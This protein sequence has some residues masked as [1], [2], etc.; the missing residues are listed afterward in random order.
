[1]QAKIAIIG[2]GYVGIL[3]NKELKGHIDTCLQPKRQ[4]IVILE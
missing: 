3:I 2:L 4:F 1:M